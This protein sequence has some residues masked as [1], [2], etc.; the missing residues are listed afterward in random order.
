MRLTNYTCIT[1]IVVDAGVVAARSANQ[2]F[3]YI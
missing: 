2:T 3:I 1:P